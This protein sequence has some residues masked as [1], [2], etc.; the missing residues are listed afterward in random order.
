MTPYG[1][2]VRDARVKVRDVPVMDRPLPGLSPAVAGYFCIGGA[3][4]GIDWAG[5]A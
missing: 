5:S 2:Q 3:Q 1:S 4:V